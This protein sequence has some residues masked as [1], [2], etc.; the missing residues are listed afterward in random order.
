[1]MTTVKRLC[2]VLMFAASLAFACA[3]AQRNDSIAVSERP[4]LMW[5]DLSA[6]WKTF[7]SPDS[8]DYYVR[9]CKDAGFNTLVVDVKG[10][11]SA[12]A[13]PSEI[14]PVL[15]EW[16]GIV[17]PDGYDFLSRFIEQ[18]HKHG[19]KVYASFNVFCEGHGIFHRGIVYDARQD[20]QSQN[21]V[22]G[23]GI[24]P[25]S[26]I[27]GKATVFVNPALPEVQDY[28]RSILVEC[29]TKYPV[30]GIMVDR[31]RYDNIQSDFSDFSRKQFEKYI[32]KKVKHW[33]EDIYEWV[34]D[35]K[36]GYDL[37]E[38]K[39]FK[40]WIEWRASIIHNFFSTT[41]DALKAARPDV[42]FAAYTGAWYPSYYEVG[43]NWASSEY[44]PAADFD[45]AT[46]RYREYAYGDLLD[47]YT[48]GNYYKNVTLDEYRRSNGTYLNET[49]SRISKGEHLCVE[50]ACL[51]SRNLLKNNAFCGGLY[52]E[53]YGQD[54]GQFKKAVRMNLRKSDG[55][56]IFDIVHI[57]NRDWWL[58]LT[59]AI[60]A[61]EALMETSEIE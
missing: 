4:K 5:I 45:W 41:R 13:Y 31:T 61:E 50:G 59:A 47:L 56:M 37:K 15:K 42:N 10:T 27:K 53:D 34:P 55:L 25:S 6:N 17:R 3:A 58:P 49:D 30:D 44:D 28:E 11:G 16:K 57:I 21:Y 26:Q 12:V 14:A 29:A 51:Y 33:P 20:W 52:V 18:G 48:N 36:G 43:A 1:M 9:K 32:G 23:Q 46:P 2:T 35:A 22:P 38:G 54:V 40:Q 7:S 60:A 24:I 8:I 19:M 39:Y